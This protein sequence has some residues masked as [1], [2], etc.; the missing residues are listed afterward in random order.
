[1]ISYVFTLQDVALVK[2]RV[3]IA[4]TPSDPLLWNNIGMCFYGKNRQV[5]A[6][7][8]LKR[9]LY[10]N[11]FEWQISYNLGLVHLESLQYASAF[12]HFR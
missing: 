4:Q 6:V 9:A 2:Y 1:M 5:A 12:L 10:L 3:A 11:P 8:C 7:S